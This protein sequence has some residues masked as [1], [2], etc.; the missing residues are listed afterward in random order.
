MNQAGS[1]QRC[2]NSDMNHNPLKSQ[3]EWYNTLYNVLM[4]NVCVN[5]L[6][7]IKYNEY[8]NS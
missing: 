1:N 7:C 4:C 2:D 5:V 3:M 6:M 8:K